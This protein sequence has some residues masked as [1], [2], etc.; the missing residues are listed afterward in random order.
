MR[1]IGLSTSS[2]QNVYG[3]KK[4]IEIA[5]PDVAIIVDVTFGT[6]PYTDEEN[7]FDVGDG[8]TVALGPNLDRKLSAKFINVCEVNN[9]QY[10]KEICSSHTGTDAWPVQVS[11]DDVRC[12]LISVPIRYMHTSV[13]TANKTDIENAINAICLALEGGII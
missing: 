12:I 5:R 4:A 11:C 9:I 1:K 2:L 8:I 13:E 10:K 6:S 7:G 3:D